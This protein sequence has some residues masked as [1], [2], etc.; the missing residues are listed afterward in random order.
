MPHFGVGGVAPEG[1]SVAWSNDAS[2]F[3]SQVLGATLEF[4]TRYTLSM[5]IGNRFDNFFAGSRIELCAAGNVVAFEQ[6]AIVPG[7][8]QFM[9]RSVVIET[10]AMHPDL[11]GALEIRFRSDGAQTNFDDVRLHAEVIPAP[12]SVMI[13]CLPGGVLR[14]RRRPSA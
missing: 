3:A 6:N 13:L 8:G 1:E 5:L 10:G 7:E 9:L 4:F 12:S 14:S 11:G 2:G